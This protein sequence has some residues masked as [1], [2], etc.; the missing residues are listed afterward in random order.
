MNSASQINVALNDPIAY[1]R[2]YKEES[3]KK[4]IGYLCSYTPEEI[5][6]AAGAHPLRLFARE[7][8]AGLAAAHLQTYC[9]SL[10]RGVLDNALSGGLGFLDGAVFPHT[11]DSIQRLSDIWRLNIPYGFHADIVLPVKLNTASARQYMI[12]VIGK[13]RSDLEVFLARKITDDDLRNS[14]AMYNQI[15]AG[16][17][18]L[19]AMRSENADV[20]SGS[21][22]HG[23]VR[24]SMIMDRSLFAGILTD[25]V[26]TLAAK[27][28]T[29]VSPDKKRLILAGGLC[30]DPDIHSV[31]DDAGGV[32][33]WDDFC[34][35]SRYMEGAIPT[36]MDPIE[37]I[38]DRLLKRIV[39]PAKHSDLH[40]RADHILKMA[41]EKKA[42]GVVFFLLK[43][44]DPHAFDY[45]YLK[46]RLDAEG[47]PSTL[48]EVDDRPVTEGRL[49]TRL[50]AFLEMI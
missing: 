6:F 11:C 24:A 43:F 50:E 27:K 46:N 29:G 30:N 10:V 26:A 12:D 19:Y 48:L 17:K 45:P 13:F 47:I 34:T 41:K 15:R 39:C 1:A 32:A 44:C 14:I 31:I 18:T 25:M 37:A 28:S 5:I 22:L 38:A 4:V 7:E 3:G 9:C 49:K 23:L 8:A 35:G 21:D 42:S 40:S 33:V 36:D 20:V 16:L 2:R